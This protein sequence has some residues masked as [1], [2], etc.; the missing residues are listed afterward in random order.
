MQVSTWATSGKEFPNVETRNDSPP[1]RGLGGLA[2]RSL[3]LP[4]REEMRLDERVDGSL[5]FVLEFDE[6]DAHAEAR[7]RPRDACFRLQIEAAGGQAEAHAEHRAVVERARGAN[8]QAAL[9]DIER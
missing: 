8:G 6:L 3:R 4:V 9:A 7:H 2:G 1:N 5:R